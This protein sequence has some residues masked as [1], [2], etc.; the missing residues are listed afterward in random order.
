MDEE[1]IF[2]VTEEELGPIPR[3]RR[4]ISRRTKSIGTSTRIGIKGK[5]NPTIHRKTGG[6]QGKD[7]FTIES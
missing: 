6:Q 3:R 1:F 7:T 5:S 4:P 2:Q